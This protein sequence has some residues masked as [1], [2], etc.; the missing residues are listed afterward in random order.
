MCKGV[1]SVV[2]LMCWFKSKK[3]VEQLSGSIFASV[4]CTESLQ[5]LFSVSVPCCWGGGGGV[6]EDMGNRD[7]DSSGLEQGLD[8]ASL[9]QMLSSIH[10]MV[11]RARQSVAVLKERVNTTHMEMERREVRERERASMLAVH[12]V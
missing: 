7:R 11:E 8:E 3:P 4:C 12:H 1:G 5:Q 9:S 2:F 10:G 6:I